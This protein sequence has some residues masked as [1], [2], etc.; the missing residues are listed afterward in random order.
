[1]RLDF[2]EIPIYGIFILISLIVNIIIINF[3]TPKERLTKNDIFCCSILNTLAIF[4]GGKILNMIQTQNNS[5]WH[6]GFSSYG[7]VIGSNISII[8]FAK[9]YKKDY[10]ELLNIAIINLP[11]MYCISKL[12]CFFYGCCNGIE[13]NGL[14]AVSYCDSNKTYF[15]VQFMESLFNFV[16]FVILIKKYSKTKN[17]IIGLTFLL[18]GIAKF[19]CEFLRESWNGTISGTQILSLIFIIL[20]LCIMYM[21]RKNENS[22]N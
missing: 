4:V 3:I 12:G 15:P 7:G 21:E 13:Y 17:S 14:G 1:M 9:L 19:G 8:V 18:C 11:M 5:F 20:G 22:N 16:I 6:A 10:K 2:R